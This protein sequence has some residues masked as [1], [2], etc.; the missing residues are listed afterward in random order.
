MTNTFHI[1]GVPGTPVACDMS[2]AGDTPDERLAA[3]RGLFERALLRR[4]RSADTVVFAFRADPGIRDAVEDLASREAAC[5]PF[6]DYR[7]ETTGN[8]VILTVTTAVSGYDRAG[9]E[10]VLDAFHALPDHAGSD[11]GGL[12][13]RLA[14]RGVHVIA[15]PARRFELRDSASR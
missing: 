5:C 11:V 10:V 13:D 7:V 12:F 14:D 15:A 8:E 6:M 9:I 4:E 2:G 3:Y 1:K